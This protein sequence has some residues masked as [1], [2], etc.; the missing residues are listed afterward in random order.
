MLPKGVVNEK[1]YNSFSNNSFNQYD[2]EKDKYLPLIDK[3]NIETPD[4][5]EFDDVNIGW[6]AGIVEANRPF[7]AECWVA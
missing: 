5:N 1:N 7:Y 4:R 2:A 6:Y 3:Y